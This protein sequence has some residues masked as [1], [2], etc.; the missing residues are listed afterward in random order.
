MLLVQGETGELVH[1]RLDPRKPNAVA[2]RLLVLTGTTW[3]NLALYG[4][5]LL[6]RNA[7]EVACFELPSLP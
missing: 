2:G 1:V 7:T 4:R 3:N 5:Y 6:V